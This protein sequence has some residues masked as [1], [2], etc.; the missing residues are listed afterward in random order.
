M[1]GTDEIR[2][3]INERIKNL[4]YPN[5]PESLYQPI[6]YIMNL[7]SKRMRPVLLLMAHQ[8]FDENIEEG[9]SPALAIEF[10]HNFTLLHDDIMDNAPIRRGSATV[11]EKWNNN[12]AILSGDV[13]MIYAYQLISKLNSRY[14]KDVIDIFNKSS[15]E[16]CEGQQ[17]DMNFETEGNITLVD[18]MKMIKY[19][20]AVLLAVSLK[21]GGI[22]GGANADEQ[23]HLYDFGI[24]LGM[25]FQLKDDLL[26]VFGVKEKFGKQVGGDILANKKTFLYL[27]SLQ[28]ADTKTKLRLQDLY[29]NN[30]NPA[31]KIN[32]VTE[33]FES[34][35]IQKYTNDMINSYHIK[36]MKHLNEIDSFRKEPLVL[37]CKTMM[38]RNN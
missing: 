13:M 4:K 30:N 23:N 12:I 14:L 16:V 5:F 34:L 19:K 32:S 29:K 31:L 36:A 27:K 8:L 33:I 21:I 7:P 17:M 1:K 15:I 37:L 2:S 6:E 26:D 28:L 25:A 35:D 9:I 22:T 10:F 3:I 18:Y 20:T 11:H 38:E 24:N